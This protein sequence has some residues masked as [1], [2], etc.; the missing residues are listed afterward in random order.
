MATCNPEALASTIECLLCIK[1]QRTS[2]AVKT[3]LVRQYMGNSSTPEQLWAA[4]TAAGFGKLTLKQAS[5]A[6][7]YLVCAAGGGTCAPEALNAAAVSFQKFSWQQSQAAIIYFLATV[8]GEP[9]NAE[10]L[11]NSAVTLGFQNLP[12]KA[13][14]Q[15]QA[16]LLAGNMTPEALNVATEC[17]QCVGQMELLAMETYAYCSLTGGELVLMTE[18][19]ALTDGT[20]LTTSFS[21]ST[22]PQYIRMV[23]VC[24][25]QDVNGFYTFN[26]GD[27]LDCFGVFDNHLYEVPFA[28]GY[29]AAGS[30]IF[31]RYN[32]EGGNGMRYAYGTG[33]FS[34]YFASMS[35]FSMKVY[36]F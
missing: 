4:A 24:T 34:A 16:Y 3:W 10:T 20:S 29:Q 1:G 7:V 14:R 23:L 27:E 2:E 32:G 19:F 28:C 22:K 12:V 18:Q 15:I 21:V 6:I 8:T 30:A 36:Y 33:Q 5:Q 26:P 9:I 13:M 11:T 31:V 25:A 35:N 17:F